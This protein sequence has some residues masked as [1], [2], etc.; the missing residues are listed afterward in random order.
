MKIHTIVIATL[1]FSPFVLSS[2]IINTT[3]KMPEY[4]Q[5]CIFLAFVIT[6]LILGCLYINRAVIKEFC[7][8][9]SNKEIVN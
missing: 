8:D 1:I 3:F 6:G 9:T 2:Y 7:N 4:I 5:Q